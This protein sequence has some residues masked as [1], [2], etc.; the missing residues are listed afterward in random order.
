MD[1][2]SR[3]E[4]CHCCWV[5]QTPGGGSLVDKGE[6]RCMCF[7]IVQQRKAAPREGEN[8]LDICAQ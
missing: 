6:T 2:R 8:R 3:V 4:V 5:L 1:V 7:V